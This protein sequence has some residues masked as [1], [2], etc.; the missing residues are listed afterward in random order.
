[1]RSIVRLISRFTPYNSVVSNGIYLETMRLTMCDHFCFFFDLS[2]RNHKTNRH[3]YKI[4]C[5]N[6]IKEPSEPQKATQLILDAINLEP[7]LYRMGLTKV[8]DAFG[9]SLFRDYYYCHVYN[10]CL[11]HISNCF[12]STAV[13]TFNPFP[14]LFHQSPRF[15]RPT[16]RFD[17]NPSKDNI[18]YPWASIVNTR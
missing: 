17:Y 14:T 13:K 15:N 9:L 7:E 2:C 3:R 12:S 18:I 1:M 8:L 5:A 4:L 6:A 11:Q 10:R 16:F